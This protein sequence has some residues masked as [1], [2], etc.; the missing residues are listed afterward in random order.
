MLHRLAVAA[1]RQ[2]NTILN[3]YQVHTLENTEEKIE[4]ILGSI[5]DI[6]EDKEPLAEANNGTSSSTR[7]N[8]DNP[9]VNA[10]APKA[11]TEDVLE[12]TEV[13]TTSAP[14]PTAP[15]PDTTA[16]PDNIAEKPRRRRVSGAALQER[17]FRNQNLTDDMPKPKHRLGETPPETPSSAAAVSAPNTES[18]APKIKVDDD[19]LSTIESVKESSNMTPNTSK[20]DTPS[21]KPNNTSNDD[22][23]VFISPSEKKRKQMEEAGSGTQKP[24]ATH[25]V[26]VA[27]N[28]ST[29]RKEERDEKSYIPEPIGKTVKT[30]AP[31]AKDNATVIVPPQPRSPSPASS[32]AEAIIAPPPPS[33]PAAP[34]EPVKTEIQPAPTTPT[35]SKP[36]IQSSSNIMS[37]TSE[38][39]NNDPLLSDNS[40]STASAAIQK[41]IKAAKPEEEKASPAPRSNTPSDVALESIVLKALQP[42]LADWLDQNL[43][44]MVESI[45]Q[46]EIE[47]LVK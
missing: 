3:D 15:E 2:Q 27:Q 33:A 37:D 20:T 21:P 11:T 8:A 16:S 12:L 38:R 39:K 35:S 9:S 1:S 14:A 36:S 18:K 28:A 6:I 7:S 45:V 24:Q 46:K 25:T 43:P 4:D 47:K 34:K 40:A 17:A 13:V 22:P 23:A 29:P 10:D 31:A 30:A 19:I 41:L 42:L 26:T 5:R 44:K 32:S